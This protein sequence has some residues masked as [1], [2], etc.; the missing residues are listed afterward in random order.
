M[1]EKRSNVLRDLAAG[2]G[3]PALKAWFRILLTPSKELSEDLAAYLRL[4]RDCNNAL[5][6]VANTGFEV[7][8]QIVARQSLSALKSLQ[9]EA[10]WP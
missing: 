6:L 8:L 3:S 7:A 1:R 10:C 9:G 4:L 2:R 5:S